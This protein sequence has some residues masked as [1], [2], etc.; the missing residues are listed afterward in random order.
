MKTNHFLVVMTAF[1]VASILLS[2]CESD[3]EATP[4]FLTQSKVTNADSE[5]AT[6]VTTI[7][8][9]PFETPSQTEADALHLMREEELLARDVYQALFEKWGLAVFGNIAKSEEQHTNAVKKLLAKY[10]IEDLAANHQPGVFQFEELQQLYNNLLAQGN[11]SL[12][13]ALKVGAT[14]E[15]LDIADLEKLS[16]E[17]DNQDVL[18][19][20]GNLTKGSRNHLRSFVG[21]I[22][23]RGETYAPQYISD[24]S[25]LDIMNSPHE[26]GCVK[27]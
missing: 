9:L 20:F 23:S 19:V 7:D 2:S 3:D 5:Y 24:E 25:F 17:I 18:W 16:D 27:P 22:E 12:M 15:D 6:C 4:T 14:I 21:Q 13:D 26:T 11:V 10:G 1:T 8:S